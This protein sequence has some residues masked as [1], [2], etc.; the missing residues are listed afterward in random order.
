MRETA[1]RVK[2]I[3]EPTESHCTAISFKYED[4]APL[5]NRLLRSDVCII[6]NDQDHVVVLEEVVVCGV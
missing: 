6:V 1:F 5:L 2:F 3:K 4:I